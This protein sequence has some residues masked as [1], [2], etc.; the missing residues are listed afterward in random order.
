[1]P[2]KSK[3]QQRYMFAK[4]P[5][6]ARE[7]ADKMKEEGIGYKSLPQH[8]KKAGMLSGIGKSVNK[9]LGPENI[10][11]TLKN[12][13]N[14]LHPNGMVALGGTGMLAASSLTGNKGEKKASHVAHDLFFSPEMPAWLEYG[15]EKVA[16]AQIPRKPGMLF[17]HAQR[18][19]QAAFVPPA[20]NAGV[21][22]VYSMPQQYDVKPS[23][24]MYPYEQQQLARDSQISGRAGGL[25]AGGF[26]GYHLGNAI[27]NRMKN[28]SSV[29]GRLLGTAAGAGLGALAGGEGM[30]ALTKRIT[31]KSVYRG[32]ESSD[33]YYGGMSPEAMQQV[34]YYGQ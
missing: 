5:R 28:Q 17:K 15:V 10:G 6:I 12:M 14:P 31:D 11:K 24:M 18:K 13:T 3:A 22:D 2:F 34:A 7:M 33:P 23:G 16:A 19:E 30:K 27:A 26:G 21:S 25:V 1:M 4:H 32:E 20:G 8:V 29:I 9:V